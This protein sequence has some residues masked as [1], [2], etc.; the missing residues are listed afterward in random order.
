MHAALWQI[1]LVG[2][3]PCLAGAI[4]FRVSWRLCVFVA[5]VV[6]WGLTLRA[7]VPGLTLRVPILATEPEAESGRFE[8]GGNDIVLTTTDDNLRGYLAGGIGH[9]FVIRFEPDASR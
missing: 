9:R 5:I 1:A 7:A 6:T 3:L 8:L 2:S 4:V